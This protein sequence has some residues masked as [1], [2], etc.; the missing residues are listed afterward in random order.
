IV[1]RPGDRVTLRDSNAPDQDQSDELRAYPQDMLTS[2]LNIR[3]VH[4]SATFGAS[5]AGTA[6]MA[7]SAA[8]PAS[9]RV[10]DA[11]ANLIASREL[12]LPVIALALL[13]AL[14]LGAGHALTPGHG[15]T[16]VA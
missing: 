11:F 13:L 4:A 14:L 8:Q 3:E 2:P 1:V 12:T 5:P 16:I 10:P 9:A 7:S 15:K 6:A